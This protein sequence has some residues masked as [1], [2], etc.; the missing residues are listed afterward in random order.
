[1]AKE[2]SNKPDNT[3]GQ[4]SNPAQFNIEMCKFKHKAIDQDFEDLKSDREKMHEEIKGM[5]LSLKSDIKDE[6]KE[7]VE[8]S[9]NNL[10]DKIVLTQKTLGDKIDALNEFDDTLKGNGD[11]GV[12][13]TLRNFTWKLRVLFALIVLI[14][15]LVLGGNFR[16]ITLEKIKNIFTFNNSVPVGEVEEK[17]INNSP[18]IIISEDQNN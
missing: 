18:R 16:G 13:E 5:I 4:P 14:I 10:R 7:S 15:I 11:P 6:I 12:W 8:N 9:H 2:N 3:N 1:M 17:P